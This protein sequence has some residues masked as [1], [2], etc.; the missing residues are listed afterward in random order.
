MLQNIIFADSY[1]V[2]YV[3]TCGTIFPIY[4]LYFTCIIDIVCFINDMYILYK[5]KIFSTSLIRLQTKFFFSL[6]TS[7]KTYLNYRNVFP[8]YVQI[9]LFYSFSFSSCPSLPPPSL[10]FL[11]ACFSLSISTLTRQFA[12]Y[13][14]NARTAQF[15]THLYIIHRKKM[16]IRHRI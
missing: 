2:D 14:Q 7:F 10:S 5:Q 6:N 15:G 12:F 16:R 8:I 9:I 1:I 4:T 13:E 3:T 11:S